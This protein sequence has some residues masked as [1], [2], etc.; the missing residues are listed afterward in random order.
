MSSIATQIT[1]L[2]AGLCRVL[3]LLSLPGLF[4]TS[5]AA[6][7]DGKALHAQKCMS[8]HKLEVYQRTGRKVKTL[9]A[10]KARVA[11]C[12]RMNRTGW[13]DQQIRQV[14]DYLN[15]SFYKFSVY[16]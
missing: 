9:A 6:A 4:S 7:M 5:V 1:N 2:F 11:G 10:L 8:C 14:I 15:R 3:L 13:S 12:A 16:Q